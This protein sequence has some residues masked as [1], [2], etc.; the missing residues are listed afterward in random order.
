MEIVTI[1]EETVVAG[2]WADTFPAGI[3]GAH[4]RLHHLLQPRAGRQYWGISYPDSTTQIKYLAAASPV[5]ESE[6]AALGNNF[7]LFTGRYAAIMVPDFTSH[8]AAIS[9]TF[10]QLLQH[11]E[12]APNGYCLEKYL[13]EQDMICMVPLI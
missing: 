4:E 8:P 3:A 2:V 7:R 1:A 5:T 12:L 9:A 6:M 13:N 11:P 10:H